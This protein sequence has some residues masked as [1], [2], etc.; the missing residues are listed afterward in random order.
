LNGAALQIDSDLALLQ[1]C[2]E[3]DGP[4]WR[5]LYDAHFE[6]VERICRRLGT[7]DSELDDVAQDIFLI[8]Y[9]RLSD[10]REGRVTTWLYRIA[11]NVVSS[12]HRRRRIRNAL[13]GIF[14]RSP[15]APVRSADHDYDAAEAQAAV[16]QVLERMAPKK[17][18]VFAL[19]ELE[20]LS[21][22]EIAER[23][24][25]KVETVWTR[26]HY[27]RADFERIARKRRLP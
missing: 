12:R 24:G 6:F 11:A 2:K 23:V 26:L 20:G 3:G 7:P 4:A 5:Q 17:R 9:R 8:A 1:R 19:F 22:E 13:L 10:F 21:G 14:G 27:A 25:C 18:E 16:A 15:P